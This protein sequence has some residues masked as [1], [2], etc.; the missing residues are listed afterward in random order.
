MIELDVLWGR[1]RKVDIKGLKRS[2]HVPFGITTLDPN[3]IDFIPTW[4]EC[5]GVQWTA[6]RVKALKVWAVQ[7]IARNKNYSEP[8][9]QVVRYKGYKVPKLKIFQILVIR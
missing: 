2:S 7:I 6:R 3:V 1:P 4:I 5:S 9:F 8:W